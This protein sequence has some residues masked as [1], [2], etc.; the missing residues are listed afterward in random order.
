ML[1][2]NIVTLPIDLAAQAA[3]RTVKALVSRGTTLERVI[4]CTVNAE[5]THAHS[6]ALV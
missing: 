3:V 6:A 5:A 1:E 2:A 4:F